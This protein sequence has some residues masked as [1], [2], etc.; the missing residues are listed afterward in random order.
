MKKYTLF[1]KIL[2]DDPSA[3]HKLNIIINY[4]GVHAIF[5]YKFTHILWK[6]KLKTLARFICQIARFLTAVEIHPGATIGKRCF[7]D[8]GYGVVIGETT[9]IG[10]DCTIYH[11][12][13]LGSSGRHSGPQR[14]HPILEDGV[15]VFAGAKI[16]GPITL[17]KGTFVG[18]NS[19]VLK[20]TPPYSTVVGAPAKVV[21]ISKQ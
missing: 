4:P 16:I 5:F 1:D 3:K 6:L 15:S 18:T 9:I 12:V 7:I 10:D 21:K 2:Q 19:V 14:R 17:G 8:H 11:G 13:T 20:D